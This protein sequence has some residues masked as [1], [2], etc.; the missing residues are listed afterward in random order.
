MHNGGQRRGL[1]VFLREKFPALVQLAEV[2][3]R[4]H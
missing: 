3:W 4:L 1:G 2:S